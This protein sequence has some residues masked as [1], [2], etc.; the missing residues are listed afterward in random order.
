MNS[1]LGMNVCVCVLKH[2]TMPENILDTLC[3][4]KGVKTI[5]SNPNVVPL[6]VDLEAGSGMPS[7]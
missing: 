3:T 7:V 2:I 6:C 5:N 4:K 1:F